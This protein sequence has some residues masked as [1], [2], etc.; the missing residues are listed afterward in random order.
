MR[1]TTL[2]TM[3]GGT[4][5][6]RQKS[7][8][9]LERSPNTETLTFFFWKLS[10]RQKSVLQV[11]SPDWWFPWHTTF[12]SKTLWNW[13]SELISKWEFIVRHVEAICISRKAIAICQLEGSMPEKLSS[14][15][16]NIALRK[17]STFFFYSLMLSN[18]K[19]HTA[20]FHS[21]LLL[22]SQSSFRVFFFS[23]FSFSLANLKLAAIF[24]CPKFCWT[25]L[26]SLRDGRIDP[27]H[28][29]FCTD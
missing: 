18:Y 10:F 22:Q 5:I 4:D 14:S 15:T 29:S 25:S 13:N 28:E 12:I 21:L 1:S 2:K 23:F 27:D 26:C 3:P 24:C 8:A 9:I 19:S 16:L 20:I 11:K 17:F 7:E 6:F